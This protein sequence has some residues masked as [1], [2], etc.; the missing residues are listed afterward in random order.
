M[1][2]LSHVTR[3]DGRSRAIRFIDFERRQREIRRIIN[4]ELEDVTAELTARRETLQV[5]ADELEARETLSGHDVLTI[6]GP[7]PAAIT[8]MTAAE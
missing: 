1:F 5:L 8:T 2:L 6:I 3:A 4:A 7:R